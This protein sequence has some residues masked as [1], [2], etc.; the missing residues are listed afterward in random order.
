MAQQDCGIADGL[1][2]TERPS[3]QLGSQSPLLC[4]VA[5]KRRNDPLFHVL[6]KFTHAHTPQTQ[7]SN[8]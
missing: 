6:G 3:C 7:N 1:H 8:P 2:N 4:E 5:D